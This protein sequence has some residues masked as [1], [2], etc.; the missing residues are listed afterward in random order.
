MTEIETE[1]IH[2]EAG[3]CRVLD[4]I[5]RTLFEAMQHLS[6]AGE[7]RNWGCLTE[8][9]VEFYRFAIETT[10]ELREKEVL[11]F[12]SYDDMIRRGTQAGENPDSDNY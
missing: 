4:R 2:R 9:E 3:R 1:K 10:L 5:G 8:R 7:D 12:L 11:E 6:S